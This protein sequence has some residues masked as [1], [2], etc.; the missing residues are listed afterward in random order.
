M[1]PFTAVAV[2]FVLFFHTH[3]GLAQDLSLSQT[4]VGCEE[5]GCPLT[6][7]QDDTCTVS[8]DTFVGIGLARIAGVPE[9]LDGISLVKGVNVSTAGPTNRFQ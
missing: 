4:L 5:V 3:P 7:R 8:E 2:S 9:S 6:K 1:F